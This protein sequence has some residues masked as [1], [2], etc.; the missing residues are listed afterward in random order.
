MWMY[1][2]DLET[3]F[4]NLIVSNNFI[5]FIKKKACIGKWSNK[6][7]GKGFFKVKLHKKNVF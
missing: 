7:N 3:K 6:I 2:Y 4:I 1:I 5:F